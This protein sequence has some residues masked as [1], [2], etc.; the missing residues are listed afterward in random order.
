MLHHRACSRHAAYMHAAA[1]GVSSLADLLTSAVFWK[2]LE[3]C[4]RGAQHQ[5][6]QREAVACAAALG[7]AQALGQAHG[8]TWTAPTQTRA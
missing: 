7:Q 8:L 4:V 3:H 1:L 6:G 2:P 5:R